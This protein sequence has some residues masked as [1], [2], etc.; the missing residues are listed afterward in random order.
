[1]AEDIIIVNKK[2]VEAV[3]ERLAEPAN[4]EDATQ[5]V[6]RMMNAKYDQA[7]QAGGVSCC[8]ASGGL[9]DMSMYNEMDFLKR[10]LDA[11]GEKDVTKGIEVLKEY[12]NT[13]P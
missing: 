6:H 7:C 11:L 3:I 5:E 4:L 2:R 8:S 1:M 12:T 9:P 10:A 13:L